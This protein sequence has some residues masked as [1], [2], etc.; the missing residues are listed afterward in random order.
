MTDPGNSLCF[1]K[2]NAC[3]TD[4]PQIPCVFSGKM[5]LAFNVPVNSYDTRPTA[6]DFHI[7]FQLKR[8]SRKPFQIPCA[9]SMKVRLAFK[10]IV[11]LHVMRPIAPTYLVFFHRKCASLGYL[12]LSSSQTA[13]RSCEKGY[14]SWDSQ[15]FK[16]HVTP[17]GW[18]VKSGIPQNACWRL[19]CGEACKRWNTIGPSQKPQLFKGARKKCNEIVLSMCTVQCGSMEAKALSFVSCGW[20]WTTLAILRSIWRNLTYGYLPHSLWCGWGGVASY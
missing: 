18:D 12:T 17:K 6:P 1:F 13:G 8:A 16:T 11:N 19:G 5:R 15:F 14:R 20:E 10:V 2:E 3:R 9:F 4:P 7:F